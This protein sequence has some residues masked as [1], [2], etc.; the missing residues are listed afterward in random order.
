MSTYACLC[1]QCECAWS[2]NGIPRSPKGTGSVPQEV[3]GQHQY[4]NKMP[5]CHLAFSSSPAETI[6]AI[7]SQFLKS[8]SF[9]A[10]IFTQADNH[11]PF[12]FLLELYG[13][14][15]LTLD[16]G[17]FIRIHQEDWYHVSEFCYE[18]WLCNLRGLVQNENAGPLFKKY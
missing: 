13:Q 1:R 2:Q 6:I 18:D 10:V 11:H 17:F 12:R 16:P 9:K 15:L 8:F 5:V 4:H 14:P 7:C 3:Y